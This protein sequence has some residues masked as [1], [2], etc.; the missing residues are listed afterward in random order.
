MA[1]ILW[2]DHIVISY[3]VVIFVFFAVYTCTQVDLYCLCYTL[4][5]ILAD[6][7]IVVFCADLVIFVF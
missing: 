1:F 2:S 5:S 3:G 7:L 6:L 4:C